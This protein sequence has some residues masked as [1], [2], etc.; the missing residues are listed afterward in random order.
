MYLFFNST[1]AYFNAIFYLR[2][3]YIL[4]HGL[5]DVNFNFAATGCRFDK[6]PAFRYSGCHAYEVS[7]LN[8]VLGKMFGFNE[9]KYIVSDN[10]KLFMTFGKVLCNV[11]R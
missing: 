6:K 5:F 3:S 4:G 11:K 1:I 10:N 9:S 2:S 8:V 7:A